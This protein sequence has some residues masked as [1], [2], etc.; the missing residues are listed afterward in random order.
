MELGGRELSFVGFYGV[1]LGEYRQVVDK[2][3][4]DLVVVTEGEVLLA[5]VVLYGEVLHDLWGKGDDHSISGKLRA[6]TPPLWQGT[7]RPHRL[8]HVKVE[9]GDAVVADLDVV[10]HVTEVEG[11]DVA[12][13]EVSLDAL[14]GGQDDG[15]VVAGGA[16]EGPHVD[17]EPI[18]HSVLL[19]GPGG[20]VVRL[21]VI[22]RLRFFIQAGYILVSSGGKFHFFCSRA[23]CQ[24]DV[25][26]ISVN[27]SRTIA[28][29]ARIKISVQ[30]IFGRFRE[31]T[32]TLLLS[33]VYLGINV[34]FC[35]EPSKSAHVV[36][37][38]RIE[39]WV[40]IL[41]LE[42]LFLGIWVQMV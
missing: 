10:E 36:L 4:E 9:E 24:S 7:V 38:G 14:D 29:N 15:G 31:E 32:T 11:G 41:D 8:L 25:T 19:L 20:L 21:L 5:E 28:K 16:V 30:V 42:E 37:V 3:L 35:G 39:F 18:Q 33:A 34:G 27:T 23:T 40:L 22:G 17:G 12:S 13:V 1:P 26:G 2:L 6:S